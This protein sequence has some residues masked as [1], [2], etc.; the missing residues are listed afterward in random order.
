MRNEGNELQLWRVRI[1][2]EPFEAAS[3]GSTGRNA[4]D[5]L[6]ELLEQDGVKSPEERFMKRGGGLRQ[7]SLI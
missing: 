1:S 7:L 6:T 2:G 3:P 5:P 4:A